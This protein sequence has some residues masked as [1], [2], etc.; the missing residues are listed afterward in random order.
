MAVFPR[1]QQPAMADDKPPGSSNTNKS[2]SST[3][4]PS[5]SAYAA[6]RGALDL[7]LAETGV[8]GGRPAAT[9]PSTTT[10]TTTTADSDSAGANTPPANKPRFLDVIRAQ[11]QKAEA[12]RKAT[13]EAATATATTTTNATTTTTSSTAAKTGFSTLLARDKP[14]VTAPSAGPRSVQDR[15][16]AEFQ[17]YRGANP[18][19]GVGFVP[20]GASD[21]TD[22]NN[23][24]NEGKGK[25]GGTAT[26]QN[27]RAR[28]LMVAP[29][30]GKRG[31]NG[32]EETAGHND[33]DG[34][35]SSS[36]DEPGRSAL[37]RRKKAK[38]G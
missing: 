7:L 20:E 27:R 3:P 5:A 11:R 4:F 36:D 13:G 1:L 15:L 25:I 38:R 19:A 2:S 30:S 22:N 12:L 33:G 14:A 17:R 31:R 29:S 8:T 35:G 23:N 16:E 26:A 10:T 9:G 37:G 6:R 18:L 28:Q 34:G 21:Q 24:K 32:R